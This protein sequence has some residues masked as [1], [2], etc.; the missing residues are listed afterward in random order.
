MFTGRSFLC[1]WVVVWV[2]MSVGAVALQ[3]SHLASNVAEA[4][5]DS[6]VG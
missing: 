3:Q 1:L 2:E 4:S 5:G 6:G